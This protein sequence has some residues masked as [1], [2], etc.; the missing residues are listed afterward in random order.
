MWLLIHT[1]IKSAS[2]RWCICVFQVLGYSWLKSVEQIAIFHEMICIRDGMI[3]K[4]FPHYRPFV[5][6]MHRLVYPVAFKK[7]RPTKLSIFGTWYFQRYFI[8]R[9]FIYWMNFTGVYSW[10]PNCKYVSIGVISGMGPNRWWM[11]KTKCT[12]PPPPPHTPPTHPTPH[13]HTPTH[14]PPHN[15]PTPPPHPTPTP[16]QTDHSGEKYCLY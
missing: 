16:F 10:G 15:T 5:R 14:P 1:G 11:M 9:K 12:P 2:V 4:R 8:K 7:D 13:T 6:G 3:W